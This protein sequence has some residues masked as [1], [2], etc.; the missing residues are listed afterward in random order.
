M[1][2]LVSSQIINNILI[3]WGTEPELILLN[4]LAQDF[5][6]RT[7]KLCG[8]AYTSVLLP[9]ALAS[10]PHHQSCGVI[11]VSWYVALPMHVAVQHRSISFSRRDGIKTCWTQH[12]ESSQKGWGLLAERWW[13]RVPISHLKYSQG[14]TQSQEISKIKPAIIRPNLQDV[15]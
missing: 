4:A 1:I 8:G 12:H 7:Q 2:L 11:P 14:I 10:T 13:G 9:P 15:V 5:R 6:T 3:G